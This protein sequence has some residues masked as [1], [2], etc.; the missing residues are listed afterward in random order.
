M[1]IAQKLRSVLTPYEDEI[2]EPRNCT[3]HT[4]DTSLPPDVDTTI[5]NNNR[6]NLDVML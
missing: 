4:I 5:V 6:T 2:T 3:Y 1:Y